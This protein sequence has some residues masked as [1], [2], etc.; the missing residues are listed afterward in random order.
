MMRCATAGEDLGLLDPIFA[1]DAAASD[2]QRL[3]DPFQVG[4]QPPADVIVAADTKLAEGGRGWRIDAVNALK[5]LVDAVDRQRSC[6]GRRGCRRPGGRR[7]LGPHEAPAPHQVGI[8][9]RQRLDAPLGAK[10]Q[11]RGAEKKQTAYAAG[12][13]GAETVGCAHQ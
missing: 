6:L 1:I 2:R 8:C 4:A 13:R 9:L 7:I 11:A 12:K 3:R 10:R 5:V